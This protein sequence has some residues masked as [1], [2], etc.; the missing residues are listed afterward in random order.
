MFTKPLRNRLEKLLESVDTRTAKFV[1]NLIAG[2]RLQTTRYG[3]G[4]IIDIDG[5]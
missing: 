5:L 3:P 2:G 1:R 4:H